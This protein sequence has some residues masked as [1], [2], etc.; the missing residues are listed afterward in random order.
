MVLLGTIMILQGVGHQISCLGVCYANDP[1]KGGYTTPMPALDLTT[2]LQGDFGC[3]PQTLEGEGEGWGWGWGGSKVCGQKAP[4]NGEARCCHNKPSN[5]NAAGGRLLD[6]RF[7]SLSV[8]CHRR[9][10]R[11][12]GVG[13]ADQK[14]CG[15]L[16][17][18][19]ATACPED[20]F[21]PHCLGPRLPLTKNPN[22]VFL[23]D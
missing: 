21:P 6:R 8:D 15:R 3:Q 12:T 14:V 5:G 23:S 13:T 16:H 20:S 18:H 11:P 4:S 7:E 1:P 2:S 22:C 10:R 9:R 19:S 17:Y